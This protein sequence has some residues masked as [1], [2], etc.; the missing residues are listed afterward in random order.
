MV[1]KITFTRLR[2]Q[3]SHLPTHSL[4]HSPCPRPHP[5]TGSPRPAARHHTA[6]A[7]TLI[8]VIVASGLGLLV[9]LVIV[10]LSM[11]S[12]RSF[13]AIA[14]YV[15]MDQVSQLALDKMAKEVRQAQRLSS[16]SSAAITFQDRDNVPV[17]FIYDPIERTL[18]RVREG[19]TNT[20]LTDCDALE[21]SKYQGTVISNTFDAYD[22]SNVTNS[23]LLQ[24]SWTCSRKILGA[25]VNTESVQSAKIVLRNN[26]PSR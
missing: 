24:V 13:A 20:Y 26:I 19:V 8:E 2:G 9:C 18:V 6:A 15:N 7:F 16:Y 10:L 4:T 11:Y 5:L 1:Y 14:N 21:F 22:Q 3:Y 17:A 25:K 12:S 23:K